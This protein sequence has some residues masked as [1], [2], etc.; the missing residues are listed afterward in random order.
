MSMGVPVLIA[1]VVLLVA[2]LPPWPHSCSQ[3]Y[4]PTGM[5]GV[6]M[7]AIRVLVLMGKM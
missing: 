4:L 3:G 2:A 1:V 6:I 7:A 5:P